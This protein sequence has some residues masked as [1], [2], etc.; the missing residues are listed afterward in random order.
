VSEQ[1]MSGGNSVVGRPFWQQSM[2]R[3]KSPLV[4]LPFYQKNF[5]M[6]LVAVIHFPS[7]N[8]SLYFLATLPEDEAAKLSGVNPESLVCKMFSFFYLLVFIFLLFFFLITLHQEAQS[9]LWNMKY[10]TIELTHNYGTENQS[11]YRPNNGNE[12]PHRG[13]GHIAVHTDDVYKACEELEAAGV[14]FRKRPNEGN[15]KGLAFALDPDGLFSSFYFYFV[16]LSS[17]SP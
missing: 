9:Y 10:T 17:S 2:L 14:A 4:S 3:I 8:F 6:T 13:F 1:K 7:M 15:M 16:C 5:G 12:E 11:D